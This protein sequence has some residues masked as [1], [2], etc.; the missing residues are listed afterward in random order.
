MASIAQAVRRIKDN[1][2]DYLESEFIESLCREHGSKRGH[3]LASVV[4]SQ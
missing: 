4:S 2:A 3:P 1:L